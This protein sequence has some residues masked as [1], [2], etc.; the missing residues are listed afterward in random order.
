[1]KSLAALISLFF[2][3]CASSVAAANI[4]TKVDWVVSASTGPYDLNQVF[5]TNV[6]GLSQLQCGSQT[7]SGFV[8]PGGNI[9]EEHSNHN[10]VERYS[11]TEYGRFLTGNIPVYIIYFG[12][13]HTDLQKNLIENF[14]RYM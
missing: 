8:C 3:N 5:H 4:T 9:K 7:G 12:K 11:E 2:L 6:G 14:V 10:M 13:S 1:M